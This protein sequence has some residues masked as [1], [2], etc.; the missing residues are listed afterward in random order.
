LRGFLSSQ[1]NR[2]PKNSPPGETIPASRQPC[3]HG[4]EPGCALDGQA[5]H[6]GHSGSNVGK[7]HLTEA[8]NHGIHGGTIDLDKDNEREE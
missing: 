3:R 4:E 5:W 1:S 8:E 6:N 2:G 7:R